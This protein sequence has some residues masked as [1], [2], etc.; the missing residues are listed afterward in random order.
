MAAR[1]ATEMMAAL[2]LSMMLLPVWSMSVPLR[3][4]TEGVVRGQDGAIDASVASTRNSLR[5]VKNMTGDQLV[6][7][8]G[9]RK[10]NT[11]SK[12]P[13]HCVVSNPSWKPCTRTV[14][15]CVFIDLGA[16][17]GNSFNHF[18]D[19]GYGEVGNCPSAQWS[20]V[21]VE[22][23]PHF[24][25]PLKS[26]GQ[27]WLHQVNVMSSTAAYMCESSTS[28]FLDSVNTEKN[29]WGSSMSSNHPDVQASGKQK[30]TVP[31]VNLNRILYENTISS[32]WV[33]V[34]MDI[35]GSEYDVLPCVAK[36]PTA[37]LIDRLYLEQH[38]VSWGMSGTTAPEMEAAKATLRSKGVDIPPY[39]SWTL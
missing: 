24:N 27:T 39:F 31:T 10:S 16:A 7:L 13:C 33:M 4:G 37:S 36:A 15:R 32:D 28:F 3:T 1:A 35:E 38:D 11:S 29:Y 9:I 14:P 22:A 19:N 18:L 2:A 23:N 25:A 34:K 21:L 20:A 17:D 6:N 30:V 5:G 12:M 26:V 8:A